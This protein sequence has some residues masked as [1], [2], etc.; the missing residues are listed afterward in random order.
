MRKNLNKLKYFL[1]QLTLNVGKIRWLKF[2]SEYG[3]YIKHKKGKEN[4]FIDALNR[5][6]HEMHATT[7]SMHK[8]DLEDKILVVSNSSQHYVQIKESMQQGK[9]TNNI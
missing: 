2:P 8:F 7:I 1:R 3:F 9:A 6:V 4:K 5:K